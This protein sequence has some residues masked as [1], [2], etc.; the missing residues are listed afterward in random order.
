MPERTSVVLPASL[1]KQAVA[2]ARIEGISFAELIRRSL[3]ERLSSQPAKR[4]RRK[5]DPLFDD[6][7]VY[8]GPVLP[9]ISIN[10]DKYLYDEPW[11]S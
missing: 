8:E 1:K 3:K 5:R 9:D 4:K 10:H 2:R 6:V 7:A 11:C